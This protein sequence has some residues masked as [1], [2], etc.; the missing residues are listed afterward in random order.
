MANSN[1]HFRTANAH[2]MA[3]I[4]KAGETSSIVA[5]FDIYDH[6]GTKLWAA[7]QAVSPK[8]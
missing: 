6:Q 3:A 5:A 7:T 2:V 1:E 4:V 8:L